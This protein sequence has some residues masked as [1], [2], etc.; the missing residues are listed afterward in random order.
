MFIFSSSVELFSSLTSETS[1]TT[2]QHMEPEESM[3]RNVEAEPPLD[4][5]MIKSDGDELFQEDVK[6]MVN[7][8]D[9]KLNQE[10]KVKLDPLREDQLKMIETPIEK[11]FTYHQDQLYDEKE[12]VKCDQCDKLFHKNSLRRHVLEVHEGQRKKETKVQCDQ[13]DKK[14]NRSKLKRH[15]LEVHVD[16]NY[17]CHIC[18]QEFKVWRNLQLHL[19]NVVCAPTDEEGNSSFACDRC[20]KS[21]NTTGKLEMHNKTAKCIPFDER[22]LKCRICDVQLKSHKT[23]RDHMHAMHKAKR[24]QCE[25]CGHNVLEHRFANHVEKCEIT[26][27]ELYE[28]N[29]F[30]CDQCR[31][32]FK[33]LI[34][35]KRHQRFIHSNEKFKCTHCKKI[36]STKT[37][38]NEHIAKQHEMRVFNCSFCEHTFDM[39]RK[40]VKHMETVHNDK[41]GVNTCDYCG[42]KFFSEDE[43]KDH[44]CKRMNEL[45]IPRPEKPYFDCEVCSAKLTTVIDLRDHMVVFHQSQQIYCEFCG[46]HVL[47]QNF[48]DHIE[49][50]ETVWREKFANNIH[51]CKKCRRS[52]NDS[53]NCRSHYRTVHEK[54]KYKC[55]HCAQEFSCRHNMKQ[56]V[57]TIHQGLLIFCEHC[58][59]S[60]KSSQS[61]RYHKK[62]NHGYGEKLHCERCGRTFVLKSDFRHHNCEKGHVW[63]WREGRKERAPKQ[64]EEQLISP[65][66]S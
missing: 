41:D 31:K 27:K 61:L 48:Y 8:Q 26:F 19:E 11:S 44:I 39:K 33:L 46:K 40:M 42:K 63:S 62:R 59:Q 55:E 9:V 38:R 4:P 29:E 28:N 21:F 56:H 1:V 51:K 34:A 60:F 64:T 24:I 43:F 32:S 35:L 10:V 7:F 15:I 50:C 22:N 53:S 6:P 23:Y 2:V 25:F 36:F 3:E 54:V 47:T 14:L 66:T 30:Q 37:R 20:H 5:I 16:K 49:N 65:K 58:G 17:S 52:W 45:N 13:C 57:Q 12:S 18:N